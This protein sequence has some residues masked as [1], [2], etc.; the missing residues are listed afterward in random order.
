MNFFYNFYFFSPEVYIIMSL[1][2][3][4][5]F[6]VIFSTSSFYGYPILFK[7]VGFLVLQISI[8]TFILAIFQE[9]QLVFTWN[10]F[11][12][13]D[14]FTYYA[15][16]ILILTFISWIFLVFNHEDKKNL[17]LFEF[18]VL[19][20][21]S[22]IALSCVIHSFDL[23]TIYLSI[24]L[25]SLTF[26]IL[27]S[28]NRL[29]EFS[30]EAGLKYF[31]LGAFASALMLFGFTLL[32]GLTGL[33]NLEDFF[34]FFSNNINEDKILLY[35]SFFAILLITIAILFKLNVAPFHFWSPDV[36]EGSASSLT[37]FFAILPKIALVGILIKILI[38][39]SHDFILSWRNLILL[40][41]LISSFIG[42]VGA[43][44]Q[45]KWKRFVAY[46]A[47]NH[48]SFVLLALLASDSEAVSSALF[49]L[50]VYIVTSF[51][52]FSVVLSIKFF[53][54]P[55][56]IPSRFILDSQTLKQANPFLAFYLL[57][58]IFS[59]AGVPPLAGFF[60][61]F[62]TL[63]AGVKA[64]MYG[65]PVFLVV[66]NCL[67]SFYYIR[68]IKIIYFDEAPKIVLLKPTDKF[69]AILSSSCVIFIICIFIDIELI[70]VITKLMASCF[71]KF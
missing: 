6:G 34:L 60:A 19:V 52:F 2:T 70:L 58:A 45:T 15:R 16:L 50:I 65:L 48:M 61:K 69:N 46:S 41:C 11:L 18:W 37:A 47:I 22:F 14:Y 30:T 49:Y 43:L 54:F 9:P 3:L 39:L 1:F 31:I 51:L 5:L 26:Y 71:N 36:Y 55:K 32:Y 25:Q 56:T 66:F 63:F 38:F 10:K 13:N 33:T 29:S 28:F 67:A 53:K 27:A 7:N 42:T 44:K 24:E 12:I 8:F 17:N 21:L 35:G 59:M 40:C 4:I 62:F 20:L 57:I 64:K 68:F 23:L